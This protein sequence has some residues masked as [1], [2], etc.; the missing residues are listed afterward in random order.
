MN[1]CCTRVPSLLEMCGSVNSLIHTPLIHQGSANESWKT[2]NQILWRGRQSS[3]IS[4]NLNSLPT[5]DTVDAF[6]NPF[7]NDVDDLW[8]NGGDD[9]NTIIS[10]SDFSYFISPPMYL[11]PCNAREAKQYIAF[12]KSNSAGQDGSTATLLKQTVDHNI[13][14]SYS[15]MVHFSINWKYQNVCL[16]INVTVNLEIIIINWYPFYLLFVKYIKKSHCIS[17]CLFSWKQ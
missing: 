8:M 5:C 1:K 11:L 16:H 13:S 2:I 9:S 15:L 7:T 10:L 12:L 17:T 6:D 14:T 4:I 3:R